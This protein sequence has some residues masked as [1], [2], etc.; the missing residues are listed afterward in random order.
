MANDLTQPKSWRQG[1]TRYHYLVLVVA[2]FGWLFDTMDQ[3]LY[4]QAK[5]PAISELLNLGPTDPLTQSWV[6]TAQMWMLIGWAT[7]GFF[8]GMIGD[9]LGRT[10]V[11]AL[12]ILVYAGGTGLC[13]LAQTPFQFV[14]LRFLTGLGIGGEFAAGAALVAETFPQHARTMALAI[15]QATSALG[16]VM[17]GV[18]YFTIGANFG[19]RW[20]FAIGVLPALLLVI[21]FLFI[22]EPE[23]WLQSRERARQGTEKQGNMF[24]LFNPQWRRNTL[25]GVALATV[26]VIGFWGIGTWTA[27]LIR[28]VLNPDNLPELRQAVDRKMSLCI[29]AQNA[30]GFFGVMSFSYVAQRWGRRPAFFFAFLLSL[31]IVPAT[32]FISTSFAAAMI[33]FPLMGFAL[34]TMFGGYAIYLPELFP[35][36]L[37]ATGTGFCYNVARYLSAFSPLFFGRVSGAI[38]IQY[39]ALVFSVIFVFGMLV[40]PF[41]PE[42][43]GKPLPE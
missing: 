27:E 9:R 6:G 18:I 5:T 31:I 11:M 29:M 36:R 30:G 37:R 38:G 13:A 26:G 7:G 15:V 14:A 40:L 4:V 42:T 1:L 41:A 22:R 19:W 8:F 2:C 32:F 33:M 28:N 16:N 34:L 35:T 20:V 24:H 23:A 39:A 17:A 25:I 10:K 3:W 43:K 21:I 12:T